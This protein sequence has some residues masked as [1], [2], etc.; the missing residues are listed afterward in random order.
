MTSSSAEQAA[1]EALFVSLGFDDRR[2]TD[3]LKN[4]AL[5]KAIHEIAIEVFVYF[6]LYFFF[7]L[8]FFSSFLY[9]NH[10]NKTFAHN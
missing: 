7:F 1:S 2:R 5:T 4:Q 6:Y 9:I 10:Q 3:T 8:F